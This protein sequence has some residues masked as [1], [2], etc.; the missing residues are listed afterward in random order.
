MTQII[1]ILEY[2]Q[3]VTKIK[4]MKK[5]KTKNKTT[6]DINNSKNIFFKHSEIE[7]RLLLK[8]DLT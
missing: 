7:F 1:F 2:G 4:K 5:T 6:S 3:E 8:K